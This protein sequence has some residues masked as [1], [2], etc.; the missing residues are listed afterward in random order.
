MGPPRCGLWIVARRRVRLGMMRRSPVV[1]ALFVSLSSLSG[2]ARVAAATR[3]AASDGISRIEPALR[4][5][6]YEEALRLAVDGGVRCCG[7][8]RTRLEARALLAMGRYADARKEL[9]RLP[10]HDLATRDLLM[11]LY[12]LVGDRVALK[13][14]VD[15]TYDDWNGGRVDRARAADLV[16]VATAAR[17]DGNWKDA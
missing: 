17:L 7:M 6:K 16:A 12:A 15:R 13:P 2:P 3:S 1:L 4:A 14:L 10:D 11:R 8:E 5:G 9:E